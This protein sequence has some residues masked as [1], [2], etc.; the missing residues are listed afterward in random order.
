M[1]QRDIVTCH[2]SRTVTS[3]FH[4]QVNFAQI[5]LTESHDNDVQEKK[6][7]FNLVDKIKVTGGKQV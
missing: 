7:F 5:F 1:V 2:Q 3:N 6:T 4:N